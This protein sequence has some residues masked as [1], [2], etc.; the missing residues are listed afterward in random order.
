MKEVVGKTSTRSKISIKGDISQYID[1]LTEMAKLLIEVRPATT[2][3]KYIKI[4]IEILNQTEGVKVA[5]LFWVN[6]MEVLENDAKRM[7]RLHMPEAVRL[8]LMRKK[9]DKML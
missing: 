4:P 1:M 6:A 8:M 7:R 5:S 2:L 3:D 9:V